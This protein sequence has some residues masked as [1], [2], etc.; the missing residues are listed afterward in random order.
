M[1]LFLTS[2]PCIGWAGD[3]NPANGFLSRL[4]KALPHPLHCLLITSAPD[5]KEM[6]DRMAW[7]MREIF[8]RADLAFDKYEVLD[9][10]T[11]RYEARMICDANFI[12][13]CGGH[14]P[15]EN[16]FFKEIHLR[17]RLSRFNG[18][19]MSISAGSMNAADIV[20][21][22]P[23]LDGE[24]ID[25]NYMVYLRGLGLT[26]V[27]ILPHFEMIRES[28][29]D[30]RL[31]IKDIVARHSYTLPVYCLNDGTYLLITNAEKK[32]KR[33]TELHGEAYRMKDGKLDLICHDGECK[34]I[35]KNGSLRIVK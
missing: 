25:P 8:G 12:I 29:L 1:T 34:L 24:S 26:D 22:S 4:R 32:E 33:R 11:Q 2:S 17:A 31:L 9:R 23:E 21:A 6:T 14:V 16:K 3:L 20:Y 10:R 30:G 35:C 18:V 19:V 28:R 13:L 27:N 5:D 7:D 15:T